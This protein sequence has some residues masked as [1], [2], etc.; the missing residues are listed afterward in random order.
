VSLA[1]P[2]RP[3]RAG[4]AASA[5]AAVMDALTAA[6]LAATAY[7]PDSPTPGAAWPQLS[8]TNWNGHVCDP[9]RY[10]F[11]AYVVLNG[12]DP[13]TTIAAGDEAIATVPPA[14]E[15]VAVV[16]SAEPVLI[17][18]GDQT[19]MPGIRFRLVTRA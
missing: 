9:A 16:Q 12:G 10:T 14:L 8:I 7:A 18:F 13:E 5:R 11:D 17:T 2:N 6:G 4:N 19:T 1:A 3:A 15:R